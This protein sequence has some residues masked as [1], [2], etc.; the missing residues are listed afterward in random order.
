MKVMRL[1]T[2]EF[3][4]RFL[5]HVLPGGFH[6][7]RH[8]GLLAGVGRKDTVARIRDL[9]GAEVHQEADATDMD[10]APPLTLREPCPECGGPM[11]IIET[12]RR[13]ERP[14]TRGSTAE[15]SRTMT[16]PSPSMTPLRIWSAVRNSAKLRLRLVPLPHQPDRHRTPLSDPPPITHKSAVIRLHR[17]LPPRPPRFNASDTRALSP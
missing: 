11:R 2:D 7:I 4:R 8:Y 15:G 6:R 5:L 1:S 16:R 9:L 10:A 14:M 17:R 13:G 12:F 3:I